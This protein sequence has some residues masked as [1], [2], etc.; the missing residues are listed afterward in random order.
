VGRLR[1]TYFVKPVPATEAPDYYAKHNPCKTSWNTDVVCFDMMLEKDR[2]D[3]NYR[4][5]AKQ[6]YGSGRPDMCLS[7]VEKDLNLIVYNAIIYNNQNHA[8]NTAARKLSEVIQAVVREFESDYRFCSVCGG[9]ELYVENPI[10]ICDWYDALPRGNRLWTACSYA[11]RTH[12]ARICARTSV[13][14]RH[15]HSDIPARLLTAPTLI[16]SLAH[17]TRHSCRYLCPPA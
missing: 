17:H 2:S 5:R 12:V 1:N 9:D 15:Q 7:L 4:T 13:L 3:N 16:L 11:M 6:L 14:D 10:S 8:V